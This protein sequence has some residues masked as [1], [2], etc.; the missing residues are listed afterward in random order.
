M[1]KASGQAG[2]GFLNGQAS[3]LTS[4]LFPHAGDL[5]IE[6]GVST[7]AEQGHLL[8]GA[9]LA[10]EADQFGTGLAIEPDLISLGLGTAQLL[11]GDD[12]GCSGC[13]EALFG[14]L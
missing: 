12:K 7:L 13:R 5:G 3:G 14:I 8:D 2:Q 9:L 10:V 11:L 1:I 4:K 6:I